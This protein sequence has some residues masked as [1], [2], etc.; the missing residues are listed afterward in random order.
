MGVGKGEA[1][2]KK[3]ERKEPAGGGRGKA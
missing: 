2:G 1:G 3:V